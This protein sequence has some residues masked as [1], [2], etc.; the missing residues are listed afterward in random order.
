MSACIV[1]PGEN[2]IAGIMDEILN[3]LCESVRCNGD[4]RVILVAVPFNQNLTPY[5]CIQ[6]WPN[7]VTPL[8]NVSAI[9]DA[10]VLGVA[11]KVHERVGHLAQMVLKC[12]DY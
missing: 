10:I 2:G 1:A 8:P 4:Q 5:R 9:L 11:R 3:R 7:V 12:Q 6:Q